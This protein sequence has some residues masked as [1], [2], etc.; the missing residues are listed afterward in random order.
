MMNWHSM[1]P[2]E[3]WDAIT[4]APKKIAGPWEPYDGFKL[5]RLMHRRADPGGR[6]VALE[7]KPGDVTTLLEPGQHPDRASADAALRAAGW[8][9]VD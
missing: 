4:S 9:L 8:I 3:A 7:Y 6:N 5:E 2:R 1:T